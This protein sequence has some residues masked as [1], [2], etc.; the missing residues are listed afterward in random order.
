[1]SGTADARALHRSPR[2][3][4]VVTS[5]SL[6]HFN[7]SAFALNISRQGAHRTKGTTLTNALLEGEVDG[8]FNVPPASRNAFETS[9][10]GAW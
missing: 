5:A 4:L 6:S 10:G 1:M 7:K 3:A 2:P 9:N 8:A